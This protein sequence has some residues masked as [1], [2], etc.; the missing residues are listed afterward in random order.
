MPSIFT[1][2]LT[3][4]SA[5]LSHVHIRRCTS[6]P[7]IT[8]LHAPQRGAHTR[9]TRVRMSIDSFDPPHP[10][11]D[12]HSA[13]AY[14]ASISTAPPPLLVGVDVAGPISTT[15]SCKAAGLELLAQLVHLMPAVPPKDLPTLSLAN[16][17][18]FF[19]I[20]KKTQT[21]HFL[22][23]TILTF[24]SNFKSAEL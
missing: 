5:S 23:E 3:P 24:T 15:L 7:H 1:P 18:L 8:V 22:S 14:Q 17:T 21:A 2:A 9:H 12:P 16:H 10:P 11:A 6:A 19:G 4:G 13:H 20:E